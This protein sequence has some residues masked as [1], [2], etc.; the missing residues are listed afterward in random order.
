[1]VSLIRPFLASGVPT[2][3]A[4]LWPV[5]EQA[6]SDLMIEFHRQRRLA[7]KSAGSALQAAEIK[8]SESALFKHPYYWAPFILVGADN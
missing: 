5:N 6:T 1:M 3:A 7:N 4:S 8:L 2:V